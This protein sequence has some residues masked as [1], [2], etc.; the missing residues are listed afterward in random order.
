[1][2]GFD[3]LS[4]Y[5]KVAAGQLIES[6]E[7]MRL[8]RDLVAMRREGRQNMF[9]S[10]I[11]GGKYGGVGRVTEANLMGPD[12]GRIAALE[13]E[14][15]KILSDAMKQR[16]QG[17]KNLAAMAQSG[18]KLAIAYLNGEAGVAAAKAAAN[19]SIYNANSQRLRDLEKSQFEAIQ[20]T[21]QSNIVGILRS[22][23]GPVPE[24]EGSVLQAAYRDL[25][26]IPAGTFKITEIES[27]LKD[28]LGPA[29]GTTP[30]EKAAFRVMLTEKGIT[31]DVLADIGLPLSGPEQIVF[32]SQF[33]NAAQ[34]LQYLKKNAELV[35]EVDEALKKSPKG[36]SSQGDLFAKAGGNLSR[37]QAIAKHLEALGGQTEEERKALLEATTNPVLPEA[38]ERMDRIDDALGQL[39]SVAGGTLKKEAT[40]Y[41]RQY[42]A[43][44]ELVKTAVSSAFDAK[45]LAAGDD[46]EKKAKITEQRDNMLAS[47]D[48]LGET[49]RGG[50]RIERALIG[51]QKA[52]QRGVRNAAEVN[53][54]TGDVARTRARGLVV[55]EEARKQQKA[56][57]TAGARAGR[58]D[59]AEPADEKEALDAADDAKSMIGDLGVG[60]GNRPVYERL[61]KAPKVTAPKAPEGDDG[62]DPDEDEAEPEADATTAWQGIIKR[63]NPFASGAAK[64]D[65]VASKLDAMRGKPLA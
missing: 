33:A 28:Y 48:K 6:P 15:A 24:G 7:V 34:S 23:A 21:G 31:T 64:R 47:V 5:M 45:L 16:L 38:K 43:V 18:D 26:T 9:A 62:Q 57:I 65:L 32:D 46:A 59:L 14:R 20:G 3:G 12:T 44:P 2:A 35:D 53:T 49:G 41:L 37:T 42:P 27:K 58:E 61:S 50:R 1:M 52:L 22:A 54:E 25:M 39:K 63:R 30:A 51:E 56:A 19:A 8:T 10:I 60:Q 36:A 40:L 4:P 11:S 17:S 13:A 55:S 29:A